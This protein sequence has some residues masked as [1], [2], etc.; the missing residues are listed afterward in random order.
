M[1]SYTIKKAT[2]IHKKATR[3]FTLKA[4]ESKL[5]NSMMGVN[6][7]VFFLFFF[8]DLL[9]MIFTCFQEDNIITIYTDHHV[10]NFT[11]AWLLMYCVA[12][13]RIKFSI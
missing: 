7:W 11:C 12:Y 8:K 9:S 1:D 13:L 4:R 6:C 2:N 5:L 10:K 3:A